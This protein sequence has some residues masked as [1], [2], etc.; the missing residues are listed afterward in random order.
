[1]IC[2][3]LCFH[4]AWLCKTCYEKF[5]GLQQPFSAW[6][7]W[8]RGLKRDQQNDRR[9]E[10]RVFV[11]EADGYADRWEYDRMTIGEINDDEC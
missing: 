10:R 11:H 2:K 1:M 6:P 9:H 7:K 8:A 4:S 3:S 5:P